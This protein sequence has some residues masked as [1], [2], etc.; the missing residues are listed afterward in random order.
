MDDRNRGRKLASALI[1]MI[2]LFTCSGSAAATTMRHQTFSELVQEA[3]RV[4]VGVCVSALDGE[5][6]QPGGWAVPYTE[7]TFEVRQV[8]KGQLGQHLT[9]RQYGVREPRPTS[10]GRLAL[11]SRL[12]AMP[13]YQPGQTLLLFLIGDSSLG[14]TSPVGL[15]QGAFR[16]VSE[17]GK[18]M[19]V[20][21]FNNAGLF[22]GLP[23]SA[24][25]AHPPLSSEELGL[26]ATN[27]GPVGLDSLLSLAR[28]FIP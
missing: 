27:R 28:R 8:L 23:P 10:D 18:R 19:A 2:A 9:I 16:I 20:N 26:L 5:L 7:Y 1:V 11:A 15:A 17:G 6:V 3:E 24:L 22:R 4:F 25:S 14:L 12:P 13:V 21:G